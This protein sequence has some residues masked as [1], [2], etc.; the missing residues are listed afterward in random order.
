MG[1]LIAA[2][3]RFDRGPDGRLATTLE[4]GHG[5]RRVVHAGG[6]ATGA[7]VAR[8]LAAAAATAGVEILAPATALALLRGPDAAVTGALVETGA[9]L[10]QIS[11][12]A[13]VLATGGLGHAYAASTNPPTVTGDGLAL[14]LH[15][16]A[17]L[18]DLE[19]VQFHPTALFTGGVQRGQL[20]LVTEAVR[21]EG[22]VLVD[23]GGRAVMA[24]RHPLADLAPRDV[25]AREIEAAMRRDDAQ[26]VWLDAT[27][28]AAA[29]LRHRFPTVLGACAA[30]GVDATTEPI[31][32]APAEHFLCGGVRTDRWGATDV[33]GLYA[34]GEVA[35]TG[36]HG[37]NRL[38]SN[39]L[40]EGLVFG[41]RVAA[42]LVLDLPPAAAHA[43]VPVGM[44][45]RDEDPDR[46]RAVLSRHAGVRRSGAGLDQAAAELSRLGD[47]PIVTVARAVVAAAAARHESR[48]CHWRADYP[49]TRPNWARRVVV[50]LG[51]SGR[52]EAG[53]EPLRAAA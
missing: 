23:A 52:P 3:A 49:T 34:V 27:G 50:R 51:P 38:A 7:E 16:G 17:T 6:D 46:V 42:R 2:G 10:G 35:A 45:G 47:G 29:T 40:L 9:G 48:G 20:S 33:P 25:V 44:I 11:A 32:V 15:A 19:F 43:A 31:P 22:A 5:R 18:V 24:G 53:A 30:V 14:A 26:H 1:E 12:R 13:V 8:V 36:V 39:S 28:I 37:A 21:G 41:R 4:G